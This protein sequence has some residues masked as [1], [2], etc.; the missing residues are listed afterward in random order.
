MQKGGSRVTGSEA[1]KPPPSPRRSE[2][3][4]RRPRAPALRW[5]ALLGCC[6]RDTH[7]SGCYRMSGAWG[8]VPTPTVP[9]APASLSSAA[10]DPVASAKPGASSWGEGRGAGMG[11]GSRGRASLLRH[12]PCA[13]PGTPGCGTMLCTVG[14]VG[15]S[16][17]WMQGA[18]P[19]MITTEASRHC[20]ASH[21]GGPRPER[22]GLA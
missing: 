19:L 3:P 22:K 5:P 15:A 12:P 11:G 6:D 2:T 10:V 16:S 18:H 1:K 7:R 4:A 14:H 8:Q 13:G 17:H 21:A 20:P 9:Q